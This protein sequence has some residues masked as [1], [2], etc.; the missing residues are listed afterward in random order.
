M[1]HLTL[2][3][4]VGRI[5]RE[6]IRVLALSMMLLPGVAVAQDVAVSLDELLR[7]GS[8][9]P[10][11]GVYVTDAAGRRLKG[12][13]SDVSSTGLVVTHRGQAWTV[14]AADVREIDLQDSLRNGIAYGMVAVAGPIAAVCGAGGSHPGEC[15]YVLLYAFPVVAIGGV[16]GGV[17]D[18]LRHKTVYRAA[19][20]VQA[21]VSPIVS[22]GSFGTQVSIT[23]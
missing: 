23:W 8:L 6:L 10:G 20:S 22:H 5:L 11:E 12:T 3:F 21:S 16:V 1:A 19:G 2:R 17:V 9:Q 7:S 4:I 14:A 13:L 15:A 18:A